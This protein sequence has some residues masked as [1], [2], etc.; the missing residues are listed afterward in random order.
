MSTGRASTTA[1]ELSSHFGARRDQLL[2]TARALVE[3]ESPTL[4]AAGAATVMAGIVAR[5]EA[6]GVGTR[7]HQ[8]ASGPH[9][10]AR[11]GSR[12]AGGPRPV[13]LLGHVDT[14]WP[15]GTLERRPF[16]VD[17]GRAFGPGI[18][19]MKSGVTVMLAALE[20]IHELGLAP[21]HPV[22]L[23]LTSDEESGSSTSR[24][25]IQAEAADC[26]AVLVLEPPLPG[27]RAKTERRG[28]A[29]Y[30]LIV[31]GVA[32]HAGLEPEKGRSA[33]LELAHQV[34][35]IDRWNDGE[36]VNVNVGVVRGGTYTNVVAGE[37]RASIDVRF[38]TA[39]QAELVASR[40]AELAPV[41]DGTRLEITGAIDRPPLER[42]AAV[43]SLYGRAREL[44]AEVGFELGEGAAGGG[45]DGSFTAALGIPTL[46]GLGVDGDGAHAE[47]EHILIADL[48]RR[49]ALLTA[50]LLE[51]FTDERVR[52]EAG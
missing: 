38:K 37:A 42:T 29:R 31:R 52:A 1:V 14:V 27:G 25:L 4:D 30:E 7:L 11:C 44:A 26:A 36:G 51:P 45:S 39:A 46:D 9:L 23:L 34:V 48:P 47:H 19:D 17:N 40:I 21:R 32:A 3:C 41:L 13:M 10:V 6:A 50:L 16:R 8:S 15:R 12:T 22:T 35:A 5:L 18:F 49:A 20:A 2:S 43:V 28:V 33:I 24:D